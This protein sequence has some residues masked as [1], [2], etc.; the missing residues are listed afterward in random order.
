MPTYPSGPTSCTSD[1][2]CTPKIEDPDDTGPNII[3]G[4]WGFVAI[5][6]LVFAIYKRIWLSRYHSRIGKLRQS[7]AASKASDTGSEVELNDIVVK[8]ED[9]TPGQDAVL[10]LDSS[11]VPTMGSSPS[12]MEGSPQ[13]PGPEDQVEDESIEM[14]G[15]KENLFGQFCAFLVLLVS[16]CWMLIFLV[17]IIDQYNDC[18]MESIDDACFYG[19]YFIFG[20]YSTNSK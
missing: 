13:G 4:F 15:Y 12:S 2:T 16:A 10:S 14:L 9:S 3:Y 19:D 18:E 8:Q 1:P 5:C 17:I 7:V 6:L 20:D 11:P